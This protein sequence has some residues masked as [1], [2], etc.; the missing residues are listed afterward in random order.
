MQAD[1]RAAR[2]EAI[3]EALRAFETGALR[4]RAAALLAVLGYESE[5]SGQDFAFGA[6]EF[7][8]WADAEAGDRRIAERSR[9]MIRETWNG[10]E[11]VFQYTDDELARQA[12]LFGGQGDLRTWE[13]SRAQSFLFLAVDLKQGDHPRHRLAEMTRAVNRP[14]MMPAIIF[15]RHLH[16]DGSTAL[17]LA[18]IHRRAHKRDPDREVLERA[19]LIKD[20]RVVRPPP[21][22]HRHSGRACAAIACA[23]TPHLR[24]PPQ[25]LGRGA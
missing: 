22:A 1:D 25:G 24:R 5:R 18:V 15:F 19:T 21:G 8:D 20:I 9:E 17:T 6:D 4:A 7:L 23:R 16:A 13:K 11:M 12:D 3:L 10:I 14:L 2:R